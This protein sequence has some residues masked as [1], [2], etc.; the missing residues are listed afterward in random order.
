MHMFSLKTCDTCRRA[1]REMRA[2]GLDP[3]VTDV[4]ADGVSDSDLAAMW[5]A[6]GE[7]LLNRS[8][9]TW[10]GLTEEERAGDP[11]ALLAAHPTLIKRPVLTDGTD[12]TVGWTPAVR[13]RWLG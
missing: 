10:R 13:D 2:A 7:A 9:A 3:E 6:L 4:R 12:W 8:S 5:A 1:L 11:L